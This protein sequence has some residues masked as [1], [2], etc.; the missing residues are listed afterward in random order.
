MAPRETKPNQEKIE[1]V[2]KF[3]ELI[4]KYPIIGAINIE[5]LP[6]RQ[7]Q[8]MRSSLRGN[9][10]ILMTKRRLMK[11]AIEQSKEKRKGIE[12]IIPCL[13]GMPA[14][15]FTKEN[16]FKLY[17]IT[18]SKKSSAPAKA[19]QTA[20][21]D[22]IVKAGATSFA[23]GPIIGELGQVGIKAG[24]EGGKVAIKS[25]CVVVKEGEVIKANVAG[26][27]SRLGIEPME[28]G[29][30]ITAVYENG[31]IYTK[32]VLAVDEKEYLAKIAEAAQST[33]NLAVEIAYPAKDI[34]EFLIQKAYN[35]SKGLA[36][37]QNIMAD[38]VA[39]EL[40]AKAEREA[41]A[42]NEE[43]KE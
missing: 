37:E 34:I 43:I 1:V 30:N 5:N 20:P 8:Q 18:A 13:K 38:A 27:L 31:T 16:P 12:Q 10:E 25:D 23:P 41:I 2:K 35:D 3:D 6:T 24:I 33:F 26:I 42:V 32:D 22:I 39:E 36:I 40:V 19:G 9:V 14:L 4:E 17:K 21:K 29:L 15:L 11:I 28:I 7:L